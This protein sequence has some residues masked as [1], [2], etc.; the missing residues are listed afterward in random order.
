MAIFCYSVGMCLANTAVQYFAVGQPA[1]LYIVPC[2]LLP[3][4]YRAAAEGSLGALWAHL[5]PLR[6]VALSVDPGKL[7]QYRQRGEVLQATADW[8]PDMEE[9]QRVV[10][11]DAIAAAAAPL[12]RPSD[13]QSRR[14]LYK[15]VFRGLG[16]EKGDA[17]APAEERSRGHG[18]STDV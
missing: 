15:A 9:E 16:R 12:P 2:T 18:P 5:P 4:L 8:V 7:E 3:I 14:S 13:G 17:R 10:S 6:T 1:L 11:L